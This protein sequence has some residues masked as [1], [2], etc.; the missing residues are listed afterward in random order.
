MFFERLDYFSGNL[1]EVIQNSPRLGDRLWAA[2]HTADG[3]FCI[4]YFGEQFKALDPIQK[5]SWEPRIQLLLAI[6]FYAEGR[7]EQTRQLLKSI[8]QAKLKDTKESGWRA[9]YWSNFIHLAMNSN[10]AEQPLSVNSISSN[11]SII[12]GDSHTLTAGWCSAGTRQLK[13]CYLP[14]IKLDHLADPKPNIF[15][16]GI[17]NALIVNSRCDEAFFVMGEIDYRIMEERK[18][19]GFNT[20]SCL[21]VESYIDIQQEVAFK[22]IGFICGFRKPGQRYYFLSIQPPNA[23]LASHV[24]TFTIDM[25]MEVKLVASA[26]TALKNAC[27]HNGMIFID[28][29]ARLSTVEGHLESAN[30]LDGKHLKRATYNDMLSLL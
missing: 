5:E 8:D 4:R 25:G 26:N 23:L 29:S 20:S 7:I 21:Q 28:R 16:K 6:C 27:E 22:A 19:F 13:P 24:T 15:K 9:F 30:L 1:R 2:M 3:E 14:G 12:I 17:E 18:L 11:L 10:D